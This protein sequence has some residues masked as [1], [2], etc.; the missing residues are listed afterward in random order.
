MW[1]RKYLSE[2]WKFATYVAW[3]DDNRWVKRI[4]HWN[5]GDGRPGR[6]F[7]SMANSTTQ[8]LPLASFG[9][10]AWPCPQHRSPVPVLGRLHFLCPSMML[11][12]FF[13]YILYI[14]CFAFHFLCPEWAIARHTGSKSKTFITL[15]NYRFC[16]FI[17]FFFS[18]IL[19]FLCRWLG[20]TWLDL[21]GSLYAS[22]PV[23]YHLR[24]SSHT[25][26]NA[27]A[28]INPSISKRQNIFRPSIFD[29]ITK[30]FPGPNWRSWTSLTPF[31]FFLRPVFTPNISLPQPVAQ[32]PVRHWHEAGWLYAVPFF[33][34]RARRLDYPSGVCSEGGSPQKRPA[35]TCSDLARTDGRPWAD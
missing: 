28:W 13:K 19:G 1:S 5:P 30:N 33:S 15:Q 20:L 27:A 8:F 9:H 10:L 26:L 14:Q 31:Q 22:G 16:V 24:P 32:L 18:V 29:W 4:F 12:S 2:Y 25:G 23:C 3:L 35:T 21:F 6:S 17:L 34:Y 7:F 11:F